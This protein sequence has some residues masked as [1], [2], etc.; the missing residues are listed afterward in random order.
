MTRRMSCAMTID[1]VRERRKTVTRRHVDT[2]ATLKVGDRLI[3]VEKAQGLR[4]GERQQVLAEVEVTAVDVEPLAM[5]DE[6]EVELEGFPG[7]DP[8]LWRCWWASGH[9]YGIPAGMDD[10]DEVLAW[11]DTIECRR[12][13][14]RY[15]DDEVCPICLGAG[16]NKG[17][18][19]RVGGDYPRC[20]TCTGTGMVQL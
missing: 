9:G 1:A 5:V 2:W 19:V 6:A 11:V 20:D 12:I 15:L 13:A 14:F 17:N 3:L 18:L 8:M 4:K 10:T 16:I 7:D